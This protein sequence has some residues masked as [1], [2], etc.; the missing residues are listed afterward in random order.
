M[1]Q[2]TQVQE[3]F[4]RAVDYKGEIM[5][6]VIALPLNISVLHDSIIPFSASRLR[7]AILKQKK[8]KEIECSL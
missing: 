3:P 6:L 2:P 8:R 4:Q 7:N 5:S 1:Y